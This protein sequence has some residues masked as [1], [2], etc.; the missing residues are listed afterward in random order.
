MEIH[1]GNMAPWRRGRTVNAVAGMGWGLLYW[2]F[3][4]ALLGIISGILFDFVGIDAEPWPFVIAALIG[5]VPIW[6]W[7]CHTLC[8]RFAFWTYSIVLVVV[9]VSAALLTVFPGL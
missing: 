7:R 1:A 6:P 5:W 2:G 9:V 8:F 4:T 3:A